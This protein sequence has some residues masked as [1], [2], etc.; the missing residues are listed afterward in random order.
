MDQLNNLSIQE[1]EAISPLP[2]SALPDGDP[3]LVYHS[4]NTT[5]YS[6]N[7][8]GYKVLNNCPSDEA[9]IKLTHEQNMSTLLSASCNTRQVMD[10]TNFKDRPTLTFKW[11]NGI[12]LKE[13]LLNSQFT[14]HPLSI[15][16][17]AG[18]SIAKSLSDFHDAGFTYNSLTPGKSEFVLFCCVLWCVQYEDSAIRI[19]HLN[20]VCLYVIVFASCMY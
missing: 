4:A 1:E 11:A 9:F 16:L 8:I 7:D 5:I 15:R 20:L 19:L 3:Q 18:M 2:L 13:W 12:T 10:V 17:R 14:G 6:L